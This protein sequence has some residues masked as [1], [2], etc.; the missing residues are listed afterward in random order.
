MA[1]LQLKA[2]AAQEMEKSLAMGEDLAAAEPELDRADLLKLQLSRHAEEV[3]K[4][5]DY[6]DL[7]YR[8]G[9]LLRAEGRLGEA[10]KQFNAAVRINPAYVAAIIRLGITQQ[11]LGQTDDA[12]ETFKTALELNGDSVD[13][14]YRLA[15]LYTDRRQFAQAVEHM[16]KAAGLAPGDEQLRASLALSLQNIGLTDRVA[17]TWQS[18]CRMHRQAVGKHHPA[19]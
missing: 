14:Y 2:A 17:A 19:C 9:V 10:L 3:E 4:H 7:R 15:V 12:I 1:C 8:Y 18:L 13:L 11:D 16:E 6:A 5:P